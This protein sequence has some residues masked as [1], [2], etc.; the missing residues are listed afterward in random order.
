V[1]ASVV[2]GLEVGKRMPVTA[3]VDAVPR[4][5]DLMAV[6]EEYPNRYEWRIAKP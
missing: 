2:M 6:S 4:G 5:S 3:L 1:V